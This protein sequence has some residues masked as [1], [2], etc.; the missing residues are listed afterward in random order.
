MTRSGKTYFAKHVL[1]A[2]QKKGYHTVFF[3]PKHDDDYASLGTICTNPIQFY[4]QLLKK[5][6]AIIYRP[7]PKKDSRIDELNRIVEFMFAISTKNGFKRIR[8]VVAIDEIQLMV[9]KGTNDGVETIWTVGAGIGV[10]GLAITQRVQLLNET[11]WSQSENKILFKTDDRPD[12]LKSR[13]LEHYIDKREFF[14]SDSNKYWFYYTTG[15][16]KWRKHEP[17]SNSNLPSNPIKPTT[18]KRRKN[19]SSLKSMEEFGLKRW[20]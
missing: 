19:I 7:S 14:M 16:G 1:E 18:K 11:C 10:V 2:L 17:L 20:E 9:K 6:P 15:N 13:N 12:Y 8:R 4:A 5:N 3:D